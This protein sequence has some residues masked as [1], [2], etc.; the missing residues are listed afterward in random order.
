MTTEREYFSSTTPTLV[1]TEYVI[2]G[3][4]IRAYRDGDG[5]LVCVIDYAILPDKPNVLLIIDRHGDRKWDDVLANDYNMDLETIR[6]K[7]D[8]KYQKLDIEYG[9]LNVY[10]ELIAAYESNIDLDDALE[11]LAT[12]RHTAVRTAAMDR[13]AAAEIITENARETIMRARETIAELN[14]RVRQLRTK[15][16]TERKSIGHEPNRQSASKIVRLEAQ[17]D[18]TTEKLTRARRRMRNA[19]KRLSAAE[20]DA[21][22]AR[23]LLNIIGHGK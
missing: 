1:P 4:P 16:G 14:G 2:A 20:Q 9:G 3:N 21:E 17:I 23:D 15:L 8:N 11:S 19:E 22:T 12:F 18:T 13:L 5:N 10:D 7:R 6:P